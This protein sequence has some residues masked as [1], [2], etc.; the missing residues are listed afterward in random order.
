MKILRTY[1]SILVAILLF[2]PATVSHAAEAEP[3]D[4]VRNLVEQYYY[5]DVPESVLNSATIQDL[6]GQ[7]DPYS[8]YMTKEAV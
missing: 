4:E 7:L 1:L 6:T 3:L 5:K 2:L 8:V